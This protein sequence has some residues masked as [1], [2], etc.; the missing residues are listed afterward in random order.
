MPGPYLLPSSRTSVLARCDVSG[1]SCDSRGGIP[2]SATQLN[3]VELSGGRTS[4]AG[5]LQMLDRVIDAAADVLRRKVRRGSGLWRVLARTFWACR[6]GLVL[7]RNNPWMQRQWTRRE[8]EFNRLLGAL[9]ATTDDFFVIQIGACDGLMADPIHDW[10]KRSNW[11]GILVEPQE[12]EFQKLKDTYRQEQDRLIFENVAIADSDG[13]CTL[14]RLKDSARS[15]DWERG[16]AS[17]LPP[18]DSDRFIAETVK[19][20]TF[21][22]LLRR[23]RVS[24]LELLQIDAEGYDFEILKRIDFRSLRPAMIRYEHRHLRPRDKHACK[25]H[26]ERW[27]YRILEMRFDTGA[28]QRRPAN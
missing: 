23:H 14:Y 1:T 27:G 11:R 28:V 9:S 4:R 24:R 20:I 6:A 7:C 22:T 19:S 5:V 13:T 2:C 3:P 17:L 12:L 10:I 18:F 16:T 25:I 8:S 15:S 21:E 26:L